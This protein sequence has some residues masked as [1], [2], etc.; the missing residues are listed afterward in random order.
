M[1]LAIYGAGGHGRVVADA[2]ELNGNWSEIVFFDEAYPSLD[3]SGRWIVVGRLDDLMV[4]VSEY[5]G[6]IVAVGGCAER[7]RLH[8]TIQAKGANIASIIHP[9]AVIA[10]DC[11]LG[12]GV[13]VC[14][15]AVINTGSTI[16]HAVIINTSATIDHDTTLADGVHI[17]PGAHLAGGVTVGFASWVGIGA[18]IKQKVV[19]GDHAVVGAGSVVLN[20]VSSELTVVGVPASPINNGLE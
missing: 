4:S 18:I 13:V 20:D 2:A 9:S 7:I 17:S 16:G 11:Y 5:E 6:V 1:R 12:V 19:I 8:K 3:Q 14:A 10:A 15:M